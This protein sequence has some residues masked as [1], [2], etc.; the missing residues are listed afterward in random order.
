[1]QAL[2]CS[3]YPRNVSLEILYG[4]NLYCNYCY[5]GTDKNH[6]TPMVP[7][8]E[9]LT[10]VLQALKRENVE[11]LVLIGGE[12]M[13]HPR[14]IDI[15]HTIAELDFPHRGVVTNGTVV[16]REK[17]E[18]LRDGNFWVDVSFRGPDAESFDTITGKAGTFSKVVNAVLLLSE[19][20]LSVGIEFDCIPDNYAGLYQAIEMLIGKGAR[21]KQLQLHR[22]SPDGDAK[23]QMN[24]FTLGLEQWQ[25]VFEQAEQIRRD[26]G[27]EVI[28]EDGFP[29]CLVGPAQRDMVVPCTCGFTHLT[30]AP[31]GDARHCSCQ[32]D[33][34][35]NILKSSLQSIWQDSQKL[36]AYRSPARLPEPCQECD[37]VAACRG[38]CSAS[39]RDDHG[40]IDAFHQYFKPVKLLDR[41]EVKAK[42]I[43]NQTIVSTP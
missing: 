21:L 4:C 41:R 11:E 24:R 2:S 23:H 9:A 1:M 27:I 22:I 3:T 13:L 5:V 42:L 17:A 30:V 25:L 7:S 8:L 34:L 29:L 18:A 28:F 38:G 43:M 32:S 15:C 12:P 39:G 40:A 20:G 37:L 31:N 35:G 14:F 26:F 33:K 36:E 10:R 16:S 6:S 19:F